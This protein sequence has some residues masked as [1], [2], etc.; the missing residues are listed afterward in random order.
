MITK[1]AGPCSLLGCLVFSG[2][3]ECMQSY[4]NRPRL[5]RRRFEM[6][7]CECVVADGLRGGMLMM[8]LETNNNNE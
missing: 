8:D 2:A 7:I 5:F 1:P 4:A 6:G 3:L